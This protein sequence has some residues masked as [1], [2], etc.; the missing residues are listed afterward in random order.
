M[1]M[2]KFNRANFTPIATQSLRLE[3]RLQPGWSGG[4]L[5]LAVN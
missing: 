3:V 5:K 2:D 1:D 4:L